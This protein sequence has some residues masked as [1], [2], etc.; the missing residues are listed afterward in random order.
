MTPKIDSQTI[1]PAIHRIM[2]IKI[3]DTTIETRKPNRM[4]LYESITSSMIIWP[5][6]NGDRD[7]GREG[8]GD[9]LSQISAEEERGKCSEGATQTTNI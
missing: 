6:C 9:D 4:Y 1:G 5:I 3:S 8:G 2:A 7:G